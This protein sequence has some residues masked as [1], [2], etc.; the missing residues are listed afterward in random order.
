M[1]EDWRFMAVFMLLIVCA[2]CSRLRLTRCMQHATYAMRAVR[3]QFLCG[4]Q[5]SG[6][7]RLACTSR[8]FM[9]CN[10]PG[11]H[12][13]HHTCRDGEPWTPQRPTGVCPAIDRQ[14]IATTILEPL[15][16][17]DTPSKTAVLSHFAAPRPM[18]SASQFRVSVPTVPSAPRCRKARRNTPHFSAAT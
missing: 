16:S 6:S 5:I 12:R 14:T 17:S 7:Y 9:L 13:S 18:I 4:K 11:T 3:Q 10:M 15:E 2:Q 8:I 1:I